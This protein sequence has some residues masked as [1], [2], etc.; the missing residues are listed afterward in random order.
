MQARNPGGKVIFRALLNLGP[1]NNKCNL[2]N[3][4]SGGKMHQLALLFFLREME[5]LLRRWYG[6]HSSNE[7]STLDGQL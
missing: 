5:I 1:E 3:L 6:E 7:E 4:C 2:G